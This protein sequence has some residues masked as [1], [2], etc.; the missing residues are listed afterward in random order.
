VLYYYSFIF[1]S[2]QASKPKLLRAS[3]GGVLVESE[4]GRQ[5]GQ[6]RKRIERD[7]GGVSVH[8]R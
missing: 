1:L 3:K 6:R 8:N 5:E 2:V 4:W 7:S